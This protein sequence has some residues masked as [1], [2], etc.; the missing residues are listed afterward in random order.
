MAILAATPPAVSSYRIPLPVGGEPVV[1]VFDSGIDPSATSLAPWI[2]G[3]EVN[4]LPPET[5][6]VHG[7]M[8]ASLVISASSLNPERSDFPS[9]GC[10]VFSVAAMGTT[11]TPIGDLMERL[12]SALKLHGHSIK[13]WNLSLGTPDP[14]DADTF[15]EFAKELDYLSDLYGVLFVVAAGNYLAAPQRQWPMP[16]D[17][18]SDRVSSPGDSVRALTVGAINPYSA[19]GQIG[20]AGEPSP[21]SRRGPGPVFTQKPDLVHYGGGAHPSGLTSQ[22]LASGAGGVRVMASGNRTGK[23]FGTSLA[24]PLV[25]NLAARLWHELERHPVLSPS[26]GLVKALLIHA[27]QLCSPDYPHLERWFYGAGLPNE[28]LRAL[29]DSS[30]SFTL[31]FEAQLVRGTEWRKAPYPMP[32]VL[33]QAGKLRAEV[34]ITAVSIPPLDGSAGSEYVRAQAELHFGVITDGGGIKGKVPE[35]ATPG[36][37]TMERAQIEFGGKWAAVKVLRKRFPQGCSGDIWGLTANLLLRAEELELDAPVTT[38]IVCT[39]RSIDGTETSVRDDGLRALATLNWAR[40][41]LAASV[42][43]KV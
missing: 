16:Q 28:P 40:S 19:S 8:V 18:L 41:D 24:T 21:Y 32:S 10:R 6:H 27:A 35:D 30:D 1:G 12:R 2:I 11:P 25:S 33:H 3:E 39:I 42:L 9:P 36:S 17:G 15:S 4:V 37:D 34:L 23:G 14:C 7:S 43:V 13:V 26:P 20:S 31:V 22:P 5:D 38:Y 29:Y